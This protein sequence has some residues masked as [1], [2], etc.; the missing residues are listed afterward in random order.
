MYPDVELPERSGVG[1]YINLR[2]AERI[3][4][5]PNETVVISTGVKISRSKGEK[6]MFA[7]SIGD[8]KL[9]PVKS[10]EIKVSITNSGDRNIIVYP[11]MVIGELLSDTSKTTTL[12]GTATISKNPGFYSKSDCSKC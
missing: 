11:G 10:G 5:R 12:T 9:E 7:S 6:V 1:H 4:V 3:D 8:Y 2:S